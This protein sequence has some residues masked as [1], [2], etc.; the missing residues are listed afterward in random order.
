MIWKRL[1]F[2]EQKSI[3]LAFCIFSK[4][5]FFDIIKLVSGPLY[6][7]P[8]VMG[9]IFLVDVFFIVNFSMYPA[10]KKIND[11]KLQKIIIVILFNKALIQ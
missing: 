7:F 11:L 9:L 6:F 2:H 4:E 10:K 5:Y 8:A 1:D 3:I